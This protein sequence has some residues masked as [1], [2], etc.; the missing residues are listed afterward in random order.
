VIAW[1]LVIFGRV[2]HRIVEAVA[3]QTRLIP[4]APITRPVLPIGRARVT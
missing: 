3:R 2:M 1:Q 4:A